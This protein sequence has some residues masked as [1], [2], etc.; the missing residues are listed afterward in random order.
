MPFTLDDV[1]FLCCEL[2]ALTLVCVMA[3]I[4]A[5]TADHVLWPSDGRH[6]FISNTQTAILKV[7]WL[8]VCEPIGTLQGT[9]QDGT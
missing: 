4:P 2:L 1:G 8:V 7:D 9:S 5:G 6:T 3:A